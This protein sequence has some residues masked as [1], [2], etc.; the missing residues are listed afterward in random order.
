MLCGTCHDRF[1]RGH[2]SK[3]KLKEAVDD[4]KCLQ[5][6]FSRDLFDLNNPEIII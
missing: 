5:I 1:E 3:I 4:P 2:W 6:G